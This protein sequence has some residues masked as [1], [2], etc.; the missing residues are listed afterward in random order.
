MQPRAAQAEKEKGAALDHPQQFRHI[1]HALITNSFLLEFVIKAS[2]AETLLEPQT[3]PPNLASPQRPSFGKDMN[4]TSDL[5]HLGGGRKK[6]QFSGA[7]DQISDPR[8]HLHLVLGMGDGREDNQGRMQDRKTLPVYQNTDLPLEHF[9][10]N[11]AGPL[12]ANREFIEETKKQGKNLASACSSGQ[13]KRKVHKAREWR[14]GDK[15][16]V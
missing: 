4:E 12:K 11:G 8:S 16:Q 13:G 10:S 1:S 3:P 15:S 14:G 5:V 6:S 7:L 2:P 9:G